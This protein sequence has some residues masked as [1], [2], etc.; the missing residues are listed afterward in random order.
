MWLSTFFGAAETPYTRAVGAAWLIS[1]MARASR[2]GCQ[3][4]YSLILEG[5]QDLGK[6]RAIAA[7]IGQSWFTDEI[8]DFGS[9]DAAISL[10]SKWCV[11]LAELDSLGR[12]EANRA[13]AFLS[14]QVDH[15]RPPYGR[16]AK[17]FPRQCCFIGTTNEGDY[18][19]D[20]TG[21]VRFWP[22]ACT[23]ADVE[24]IARDR[25]QLLAEAFARFQDGEP[26]H[27]RDRSLIEAAREEQ[28]HRYH[29]DPWDDEVA[30]YV[31]GAPRHHPGDSSRGLQPRA[32]A[33]RPA[34]D[35]PRGA[36]AA[37]APVAAATR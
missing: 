28:R 19:K 26:W 6:S 23:F 17:D 29:G 34:G 11:E 31:E 12:A 30:R 37:L 13:K 22:V 7:L 35:E 14:R 1:L 3:V 8:A 2:P 5:A 4:K 36:R 20:A 16:T 10:R 18:L 33:P 32:R 9:K 24:G 25:E 27:L 15:Y 21:G